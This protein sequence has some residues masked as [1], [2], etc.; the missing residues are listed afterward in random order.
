L[1]K[2]WRPALL[3]NATHQDTGRRLIASIHKIE[4]DIFL[5]SFDELQLLNSDLRASTVAHNSAQVIDVMFPHW[6][7]RPGLSQSRPC[8]PADGGLEVD[9]EVLSDIGRSLLA[10]AVQKTRRQTA[11][12]GH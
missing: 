3:L 1:S 2:H 5:D 6:A 9:D 11:P 7:E 8:R 10:R 12:S 4:K